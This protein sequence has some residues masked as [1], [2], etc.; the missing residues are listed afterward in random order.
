MTAHRIL[1]YK[2]RKNA[3]SLAALVGALEGA[4]WTSLE[5]PSGQAE[6]RAPGTESWGVGFFGADD[7]AA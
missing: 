2:T 1:F 6:G 3:Y 5:D 7:L 4:Q